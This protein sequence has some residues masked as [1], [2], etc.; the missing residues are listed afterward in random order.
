MKN[1]GLFW[2][3]AK[4]CFLGLFFE[5][6]MLVWFVFGVSG[7]VPEVLKCLFF[8]I[9]WAFVGWL[10]LLYFGFGRFRCFCV[11]CVCFCFFVLLLFLFCL[12]CFCFVVGLVWRW[13]LFCCCF[14]VCFFVLVFWATS[15]GPIPS[16]FV[17]LFCFSFFF[18]RFTFFVFF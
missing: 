8:P 3:M 7:I 4:W 18:L 14:S 13:F 16:F 9:L 15:L 17:F 10:I 5:A 12:F 6:L 1:C 11:S 2:N